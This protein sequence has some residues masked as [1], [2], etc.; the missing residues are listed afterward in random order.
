MCTFWEGW[1]VFPLEHSH[2][3]TE[4]KSGTGADRCGMG[5]WMVICGWSRMSLLLGVGFIC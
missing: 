4:E 5:A 2:H 1:E 3:S